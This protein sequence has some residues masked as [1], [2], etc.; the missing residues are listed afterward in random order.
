LSSCSGEQESSAPV[1]D[2]L[3]PPPAGS[4]VQYRMVSTIQ[5]GQEIERCQLVVAPA[6]GLAVRKDEVK[7]TAGSHH[8]LLYKTPY[9][10]I[11]TMTRHGAAMDGTQVHDCAD[12]ASDEWDVSGIL[13]GSQSSGG[14][15]IVGELPEGVAIKVEPGAVLL[16]N[17]HYLNA[18]S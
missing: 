2:L 15:S 18:S 13:A 17:T 3:A 6:S 4:G 9:T 7:F 14:D 12:G 1:D 16:M 8:V 5:A 10:E 11:P